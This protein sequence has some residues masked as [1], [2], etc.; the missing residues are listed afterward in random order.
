MVKKLVLLL[1][2]IISFAHGSRFW[3]II[4]NHSSSLAIPHHNQDLDDHLGTLGQQLQYHD[5][6]VGVLYYLNGNLGNGSGI[7]LGNGRVW[8]SN[9][10]QNDPGFEIINDA[11]DEMLH[12]GMNTPSFH[13]DATCAMVH[14]RK[15]SSGCGYGTGSVPKNPHPFIMTLNDSRSFTFAHNGTLNKDVLRTL[16]TDEWMLENQE[17][18]TFPESGCGGDW[19]TDG[20]QYVIDS[21]LFF[22][23]IMKNIL[24]DINL[25]ILGGIQ[26]ALSHPAFRALDENKNFVLSDGDEIWAYRNAESDDSTNPNYRHTLYWKEE[27]PGTYNGGYK[28]VISQP[29]PTA[30][31]NLMENNELIYLPRNGDPVS[32]SNFDNLTGIESIYFKTGWNWVGF[33]RLTNNDATSSESVMEPLMPYADEVFFED[34]D[35]MLWNT[36]YQYWDINGLEHFRSTEGYKINMTDHAIRYYMPV[37][38]AVIDTEAQITLHPGENWVCYF[39]PFFR[40]PS[41]AIPEEVLEH[42]LSIKTQDWFLIRSNN[43][44]ITKLECPPMTEGAAIECER[45]VYGKMYIFDMDIENDITFSWLPLPY[46]DPGEN[47]L[48]TFN[49][50]SQ[51]SYEEKASYQPVVIENMENVENVLELGAFK[52]GECVGAEFVDGCP[53]NLRVYAEQGDIPNLTYDVIL[54]NS[55]GRMISNSADIIEQ[56]PVTQSLRFEKGAAFITLTMEDVTNA[57]NSLPGT[58]NLVTAVPNPFN[59][60]TTIQFDLTKDSWVSMKIYDVRGRK[61]ATL[62]SG[63]FQQGTYS[64]DWNGINSFGNQVASGVY[65]Y[66]LNGI[67]N[68]KRGKLLFLK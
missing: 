22:F 21:E 48:L 62:A 46:A 64:I 1:T 33:P 67:G 51:Y 27:L 47:E 13:D 4:S 29:Y 37:K 32:I 54:H 56:K 43:Q 17:P 31:W 8:R 55:S 6:G 9:N 42:L 14:I 5:D 15:A 40:H 23:W 49:E 24:E 59:P 19:Q 61:V 36:E 16:I 65:F 63:N 3:A 12:R 41:D 25:N 45:L 34:E 68:Y 28:A 60:K 11:I 44:F 2:F 26:K 57:S 18:Q 53:I 52:E 58:F 35:Y 10:S 7:G 50:E 20:W 38:G 39:H 66:H 30:G